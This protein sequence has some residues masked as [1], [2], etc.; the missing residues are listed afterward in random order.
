MPAYPGQ[1]SPKLQPE[2]IKETAVTRREREVT[3]PEEIKKILDTSIILHLGLVDDGMPYIVPMNYGYEMVDGELVIYVHGAK[4]GYKLDVIRKNPVCCFEM[5]CGVQPFE[6]KAA[7]QYG[8]VYESLMGRGKVE[9]LEDPEY[10]I[11]AMT[12]LMKTQT[13]KD[14]EFNEKLVSIVSVMRIRASEYT[15]KR[16]P[17]PAGKDDP[18]M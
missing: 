11:H 12:V 13:G 4:K 7:C 10:K 16:R 1:S 9:I 8:T 6:G 17:L 2:E 15:A 3:D 5:E 18:G 14:F